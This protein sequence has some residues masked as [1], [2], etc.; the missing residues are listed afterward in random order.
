MGSLQ[1]QQVA[2]PALIEGGDGGAL[3]LVVV[4]PAAAGGGTGWLAS[5][6]EVYAKGMKIEMKNANNR[7]LTSREPVAGFVQLDAPMQ[8]LRANSRAAP[9]RSGWGDAGRT[10]AVQLR[11][12][13]ASP[14]RGNKPS[15][16]EAPVR[17]RAE[18]RGG[19]GTGV[20]AL[21]ASELS[22]YGISPITHALA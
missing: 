19:S 14:N 21:G 11:G 7:P 1:R 3:A 2:L 9:T 13:L 4:A 10:H 16:R 6:T 22:G 18:G 8:L 17:P 20:N 5:A 12:R 15:A